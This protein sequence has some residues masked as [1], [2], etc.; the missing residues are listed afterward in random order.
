[1]IN[2]GVSLRRNGQIFACIL[3]VTRF[4]Q[5]IRVIVNVSKQPLQYHES[6]ADSDG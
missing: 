4:A 3:Y 5:L 6:V 2:S 1:M